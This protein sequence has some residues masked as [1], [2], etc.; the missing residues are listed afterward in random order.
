MYQK[1]KKTTRLKFPKNI[2]ELLKRKRNIYRRMKLNPSLKNE[3]KNI[4]KL[5][6][7]SVKTFFKSYE[8]RVMKSSNKN[9][10][11][12]Y[13]K[14]KL[15]SPNY[16]PPLL[17]PDGSLILDPLDKANTLNSFFASIFTVS[18]PSTL[19]SLPQW[20]TN[21]TNM[22]P[23]IIT[24]EDIN[25]AIHGLKSSVSRTPDDIPCLFFKKVTTSITKPL[26][27]IFNHSLECGKIPNIWRKSLVKPI[28][29]KGRRSCPEHYRG[30]C[31]TSGPCRVMEKIVHKKTTHHLISQNLISN[32][33]HGFL[34][35][36]STLTQQVLFFNQ[37]T[38][39]QSTKQ[40]CHAIY[41]DFTKAFDKIP[42]HKLLHILSHFKIDAKLIKWIK[43]FL[44]NRSQQTVVEGI[45]SN[46]CPVTS[47][48]PQ[49][50]VLGPLLFLLYLESLITILLQKYP[51]TY[52]FAF[53]DD[54]KL[55][56]TDPQELHAAL[57]T[58]EE[59]C[60]NWNLNVQPLKSE[61]ISFNFS[62][63]IIV[64]PVFT[65]KSNQIPQVETVRDLGL[66]LSSNLKWAPY[67][68]KITSKAN[69]LS[70]N[71]IRSFNSTNLLLYSNLFKTYIR[72]L[73]EYNTI[74]WNP[75]LTTD[76]KRIESVQ[77]RFTKMACQKTNTKF[78]SYQDR[79]NQMK[80]DTLE[81]RRTR[82]D[83]L[84][85]YKIFNNIVDIDFN[86]FFHNNIAIQRYN[87]RGHNLKLQQPKFSGST[88]R[89]NFFC[90]RIIPLWNSLPNEI[91]ESRKQN[92]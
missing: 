7:R 61:H 21:F 80:L 63:T 83:L 42:H 70:Y 24:D 58:F 28:H 50:S 88:I 84:Y 40:N 22:P 60:K 20:T 64:N 30:V 55:L 62:G 45:Y 37:L 89:N 6:K 71:I 87:L 74:I 27:I 10:F 12:S 8:E 3:Y 49:G 25:N 14:K 39:F 53:A 9:M 59:W 5:Y 52:I 41:L 73:V 51:K 46:S 65:I 23:F 86:T 91:V 36:R 56:S 18:N 79:L 2:R 38:K 47:G 1:S 32:S 33:Q 72:P 26:K 13:V 54:I 67:I 66:T 85:M 57:V 15:K 16:L 92:Y 29:K 17:K 48:V 19:P 4:D 78:N 11:H 31:L 43:D 82:F 77:R 76:I 44:S 69:I 68:S 75:Y 81:I 35:R 90:E 34:S